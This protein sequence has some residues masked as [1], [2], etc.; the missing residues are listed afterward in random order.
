MLF[1]WVYDVGKGGN[2][3][4]GDDLEVC[5][6]GMVILFFLNAVCHLECQS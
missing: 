4:C 5:H 1:E 2:V 3:I 6:E